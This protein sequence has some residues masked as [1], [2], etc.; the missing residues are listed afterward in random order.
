MMNALLTIMLIVLFQQHKSINK[1]DKKGFMFV[2]S[3]PYGAGSCI[4]NEAAVGGSHIADDDRKIQTGSLD[5]G[6]LD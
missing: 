6:C 4:G 2:Q 5:V 1:I 3:F